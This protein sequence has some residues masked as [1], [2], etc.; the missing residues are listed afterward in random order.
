VS[1]NRGFSA[2]IKIAANTSPADLSFL[3]AYDSDPVN[4][5]QSVQALA[6]GIL[7]AGIGG[8]RAEVTRGDLIAAMAEILNDARLEPAFIAQ[9]LSLPSEVDIA[10]EL[11]RDIDPDAVFGARLALRAAIAQALRTTLEETYRHMAGGGSYSPDAASAGRRSLKNICLDLLAADGNAEGID[12]AAQQYR[13]AG[14][15]TDRIAALATLS[16]HKVPQ[17]AQAIEDF[18]QRYAEDPLIIDKW[19]ALQAGIP[20]AGTLERVR[21]LTTHAAFSLSN[22]NRVRSLIGAFAQGNLTQFNRA[23]GRGY[24]FVVEKVLALDEKNPQVAARLLS[25]FKNW[26]SLESGRRAKAEAALRR[27]AAASNLSPDVND[28]VL[29]AL[30]DT[31]EAAASH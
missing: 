7:L 4:R 9:A 3:A 28:I 14:N 21:L 10:R 1:L 22:P 6:M 15:M 20:E 5:W 12:R 19:F 2:P 13:T 25:A 24:E 23:D 11:G 8:G 17:R 31:V 16:L 18:Y 27:V 26:R 30:A 29:R